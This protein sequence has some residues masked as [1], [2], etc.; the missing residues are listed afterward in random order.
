MH[1]V[2]LSAGF[3]LNKCDTFAALSS[4]LSRISGER[5]TCSWQ[6]SIHWFSGVNHPCF[7]LNDSYFLL[8]TML[9]SVPWVSSWGT[10]I[11]ISSRSACT[12]SSVNTPLLDK[13][14]RLLLYL[15]I[16]I[17]KMMLLKHGR[18]ANYLC[19]QILLSIR[20]IHKKEKITTHASF[21]RLHR[22]TTINQLVELSAGT[23]LI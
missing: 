16:V 15:A 23:K 10:V 13:Q 11:F 4:S 6:T 20:S 22:A 5:Q 21:T 8:S 17:L 9:F 3:Y 14:P 19:C 1:N 12:V 18:W 7:I 2:K